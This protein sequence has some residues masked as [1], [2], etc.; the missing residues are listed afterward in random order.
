MAVIDFEC[1]GIK[2]V[3]HPDPA[4]CFQAYVPVPLTDGDVLIGGVAEFCDGT[5]VEEP[6]GSVDD[7]IY[8]IEDAGLWGFT[9]TL[10]SP[11]EIHVWWNRGKAVFPTLVELLAHER[12]HVLLHEEAG[13]T[14][15]TSELLQEEKACDKFGM[16]AKFAYHAAQ[17]IEIRYLY[18]EQKNGD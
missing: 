10:T 7:V 14:S 1:G 13:A 5:I 2:I 3:I 17:G 16:V 18:M 4:S 8:E 12:A 9:K 11:P 15:R 6:P